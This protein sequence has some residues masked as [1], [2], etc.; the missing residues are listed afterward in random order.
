MKKFICR[1]RSLLTVTM[2]FCGFNLYAQ[3][4]KYALTKLIDE[5]GR[6]IVCT[7]TQGGC[8]ILDFAG[9]YVEWK[10][11]NNTS[12]PIPVLFKFHHTE[13]D[14]SV[15]FQSATDMGTGREVNVETS[16]LVVS[17][18]KSLINNISYFRGQRFSTSV[19]K[20]IENERYDQMIK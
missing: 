18:N 17:K 11:E 12:L 5:N 8:V 7:G 13:G 10:T 1:R 20:K 2:L 9:K 14:N 16:V 4:I 15:Y 19:Y 6:E 3:Q